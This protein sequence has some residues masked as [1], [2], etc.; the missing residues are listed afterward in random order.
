MKKNF[1]LNSHR[2]GSLLSLP[3]DYASTYS[4]EMNYVSTD[5]KTSVAE[6]KTLKIDKNS[7]TG[8]NVRI[9]LSSVSNQQGANMVI[10][11]QHADM[12]V[13]QTL[14]EV[15]RGLTQSTPCHIWSAGMRWR[16]GLTSKRIS[17]TS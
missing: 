1:S 14:A 7:D 15:G 2:V 3:R 16:G 17:T 12:I 6:Q 9:E 10:E 4:L 5:Q 13:I 11:L 8:N